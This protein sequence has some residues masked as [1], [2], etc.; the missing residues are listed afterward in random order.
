[1]SNTLRHERGLLS[2]KAKIEDPRT[3]EVMVEIFES[4]VGTRASNEV[5]CKIQLLK[6]SQVLYP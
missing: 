4:P 3:S 1:M 5:S 6:N 2:S